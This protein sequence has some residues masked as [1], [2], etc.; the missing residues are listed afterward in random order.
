[1]GGRE[2][3]GRRRRGRTPAAGPEWALPGLEWT[4]RAH[5]YIERR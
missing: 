2:T 1:M 4:P 5:P 3:A